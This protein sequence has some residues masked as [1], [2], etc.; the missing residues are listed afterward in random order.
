MKATTNTVK[1]I[2]RKVVKQ[3][4]IL[5]F[6]IDNQYPQRVIDIIADSST[7]TRAVNTLQ[8]FIMG[9]G[10]SDKDFYKSKINR[11][12]MTVDTLLRKVSF[13]FARLN[14]F[15]LHVNYN[16]L[17]E[18]VEV[19][20]IHVQNLRLTDPNDPD[21]FYRNK[22]AIYND[23]GK[24]VKK[25]IELKD[26]DFLN[27][28]DPN[29][30]VIQK[31][32]DAL[33]EYDKDGNVIVDGWSK[34]Q[35]QVY[36]YG[37]IE[38]MDYQLSLADSV[39]EDMQ[40]Q[41]RM[42]RFKLNSVGNNF[43]ASHI[44]KTGKY[45]DKSDRDAFNESLKEFQGDENTAGILHVELENPD[46][47]FDIEKVDIQNYDGLYEYTETS[48]K[49]S[50][51]EPFQIP[52]VLVFSTPNKLGSGAEIEDATS[53]YNGITADFRLIF[54]EVFS[55][56]FSRFYKVVNATGDY[57]IIP[58]KAPKS[59]GTIKPEYFPYY[60]KNEIRESNGDLP[61]IEENA[62]T[63]LLSEKLQVGGTTSL[64][65][66]LTDPLMSDLQKVGTMGVLFGISEE[67]ANKMLGISVQ[68]TTQNG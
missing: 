37:T 3:E 68:N 11:K 66:L 5:S 13:D 40:T 8:K 24:V 42:K 14:S 46:D 6:D 67:D 17:F 41:G 59:D 57:S 35:G 62:N 26:I 16:A 38:T 47:L 63:Q 36:W 30:D 7:G 55:D 10:F 48:V 53:F 4:H 21:G 27:F 56:I 25:K 32:V 34:Y 15:G 54:E 23:W 28:Y 18:V 33:T 44:F 1:R 22:V 65:A 9:G 31:Q 60:S 12:G 51:Y 2:D 58:F 39:L 61:V 49:E 29:P 50:I 43:M 52:P 45:E 19:N 64:I 20:Y